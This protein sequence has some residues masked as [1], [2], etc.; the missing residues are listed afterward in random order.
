MTIRDSP[1]LTAALAAAGSEVET[2]EEAESW[3]AT[4]TSYRATCRAIGQ[5][6]QKKANEFPSQS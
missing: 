2:A 3:S 6:W 1:Q 5:H 4:E